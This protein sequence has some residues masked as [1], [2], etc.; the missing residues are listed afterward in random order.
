M[1]PDGRGLSRSGLSEPT[2]LQ[3]ALPRRTKPT[4]AS[5]WDG[6]PETVPVAVPLLPLAERFRPRTTGRAPA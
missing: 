6:W 2:L 5:R 1:A 4:A 3:T